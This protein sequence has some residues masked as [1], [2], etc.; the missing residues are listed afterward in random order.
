MK[1]K[2]FRKE[3]MAKKCA[4]N[5]TERFPEIDK[6]IKRNGDFYFRV[7]LYDMY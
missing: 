4:E 6:V 3:S 5:N 1:V 7:S 2:L